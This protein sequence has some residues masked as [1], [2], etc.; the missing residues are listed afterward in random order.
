MFYYLGYFLKYVFEDAVLVVTVY[1]KKGIKSDNTFRS[2][3]VKVEIA[4]AILPWQSLAD[5]S[6][7][8]P[9]TLSNSNLNCNF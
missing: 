9:L 8:R 2:D 5:K 1:L 6:F 3:F 7:I 4:L